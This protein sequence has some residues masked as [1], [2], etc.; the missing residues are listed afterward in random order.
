MANNDNVMSSVD[1]MNEVAKRAGDEVSAYKVK[2]IVSL[3]ADVIN[4]NLAAGVTTRIA[5]IGTVAV[6]P[7]PEREARNLQTG[8]KMTV[9]A[10]N[11]VKITPVKKFKESARNGK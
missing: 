1:L 10:H 5:G 3:M 8:E 2:Q 9:P 7:V 6:K 4:E 11:S